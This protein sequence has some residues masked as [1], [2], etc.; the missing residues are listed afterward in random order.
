VPP[1]TEKKKVLKLRNIIKN[2]KLW[3]KISKRRTTIMSDSIHTDYIL[4]TD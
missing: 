1:P 2:T 4:P 3:L